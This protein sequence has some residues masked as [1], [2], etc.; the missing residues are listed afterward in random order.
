MLHKQKNETVCI[1]DD[2]GPE[3]ERMF[4]SMTGQIK[5]EEQKD[6]ADMFVEQVIGQ[7]YIQDYAKTSG[8]PNYALEDQDNILN[9]DK[10][11]H[12]D[13]NIKIKRLN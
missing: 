2:P 12:L 1:S 7:K 13:E 4:K 3:E 10:R 6:E 8:M 5:K 11:Q 9:L